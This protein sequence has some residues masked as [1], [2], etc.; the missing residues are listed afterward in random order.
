MSPGQADE[1]SVAG[2]LTVVR[3]RDPEAEAASG[4]DQ[5]GVV[6]DVLVPPVH[7]DHLQLIAGGGGGDREVFAADGVHFSVVEEARRRGLDAV[8]QQDRSE[9]VATGDVDLEGAERRR[10]RGVVRRLAVGVWSADVREVG[11]HERPMRTAVQVD[12]DV[13][14]AVDRDGLARS[15]PVD[16]GGRV[17]VDGGAV[18]GEDRGV[19]DL[20][21]HLGA[22]RHRYGIT[23]VGQ[24]G[25]VARPR[26]LHAAVLG[27]A[28]RLG[29]DGEVH[30][31][32]RVDHAGGAGV[33]AVGDAGVGGAIGVR[34]A[35]AAR[36][37]QREA[38]DRDQGTQGHGNLLGR[39]A[40]VG[41]GR[42]TRGP[43]TLTLAK[44]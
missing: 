12:D 7:V 33:V 21:A 25:A 30:G 22:T 19:T 42:T 41:R 10:P 27:L 2:D 15:H 43:S 18:G 44:F 6:E 23:G 36:D 40:A 3:D 1:A 31:V 5:D 8:V 37:R 35:V 14:R 11:A 26:G 20:D 13:L 4:P 32:G 16:P 24:R 28:D 38:G 34:A 17:H 39:M 29:E 9:G